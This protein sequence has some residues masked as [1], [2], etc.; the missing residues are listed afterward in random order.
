M[1]RLSVGAFAVAN[2]RV[3][4]TPST[5]S[6]LTIGGGRPFCASLIAHSRA[7][8]T[9]CKRATTVDAHAHPRAAGARGRGRR[10]GGHEVLSRCTISRAG[11]AGW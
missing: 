9:L 10:V 5:P 2:E 11:G 1:Q 3:G 6:A 8:T 7:S 4:N